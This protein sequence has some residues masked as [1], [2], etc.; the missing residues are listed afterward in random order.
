M[1]GVFARACIY[2]HKFIE[3][4]P[5]FFWHYSVHTTVGPSP[6]HQSDGPH[7]QRTLLDYTNPFYLLF[8]PI[9]MD[10]TVGLTVHLF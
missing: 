4:T 9:R 2:R 1:G 6:N 10:F 7:T 5:L 3:C 8:T